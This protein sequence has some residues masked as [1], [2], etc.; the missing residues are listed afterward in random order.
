L[1]YLLCQGLKDALEDLI[2]FNTCH[3]AR[4]IAAG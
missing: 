4:I 2:P 3:R 1:R